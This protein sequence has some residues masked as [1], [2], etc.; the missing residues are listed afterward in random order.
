MESLCFLEY[1]CDTREWNAIERLN[2]ARIQFSEELQP[3]FTWRYWASF[4]SSAT[5]SYFPPL[6]VLSL[7]CTVFF[8]SYDYELV[9]GVS[10]KNMSKAERLTFGDSLMTHAMI[11]TAVSEKV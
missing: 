10:L 11:F 1:S 3:I 5:R 9:F 8:S 2:P 4:V 6:I 7:F